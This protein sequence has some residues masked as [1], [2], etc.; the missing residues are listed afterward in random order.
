MSRSWHDALR[1]L[2]QYHCISLWG[3]EGLANKGSECFHSALVTA[4][5]PGGA[6]CKSLQP[7]TQTELRGKPSGQHFMTTAAVSQSMEFRGGGPLSHCAHTTTLKP[8]RGIDLFA[9]HL[10]TI[11]KRSNPNGSSLCHGQSVG[12]S[13]TQSLQ[14]WCPSM[15]PPTPSTDPPTAL[16]VHPMR[17]QWALM[18]SS[19]PLCASGR[20]PPN[21]MLRKTAAVIISQAIAR[22]AYSTTLC[23]PQWHLCCF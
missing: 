6:A 7:G 13:V 19:M 2:F 3:W 1:D 5:V 15:T 11:R 14:Q 9:L 16:C 23:K 22:Q 4:C 8:V 21:S 10:G 20:P 18:G 12:Q 17:L